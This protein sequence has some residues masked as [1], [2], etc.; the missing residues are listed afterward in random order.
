MEFF[1]QFLDQVIQFLTTGVARGLG[2]VALIACILM[3]MFGQSGGVFKYV[4]G[5]F[6]GAI[7]LANAPAIFDFLTGGH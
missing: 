6:F 7:A 3:F 2:I 4:L 5:V 1:S